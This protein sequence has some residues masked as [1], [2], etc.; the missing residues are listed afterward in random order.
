[1]E[2]ESSERDPNAAFG[3]KVREL[4]EAHGWNQSELARRMVERGWD[5]Y[6]Q[7]AVK[8]TENAERAV[9]LD[10]ALTLASVLGVPLSA[11]LGQGGEGGDVERALQIGDRIRDLQ[12]ELVAKAH[13][14]ERARTALQALPP[15]TLESLHPLDR[16]FVDSAL[17]T[18][19]QVLERWDQ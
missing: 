12:G 1:M 6:S 19:L 15:D 13:E 18:P 9:R 17:W 3:V 2:D 11:L 8:R 14:L 10:E 4:R 5:K 7:V 16:A